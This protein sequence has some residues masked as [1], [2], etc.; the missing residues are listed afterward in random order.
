MKT[1]F[2]QS[3]WRQLS[4]LN[5]TNGK[6]S[7]SISWR[8]TSWDPMSTWL[9]GVTTRIHQ[10][11][12]TDITFTIAVLDRRARR[13]MT[14]GMSCTKS[15]SVSDLRSNARPK[16]VPDS[17]AEEAEEMP[18]W[19]IAGNLPDDRKLPP[20]NYR[21]GKSRQAQSTLGSQEEPNTVYTGKIS[22]CHVHWDIFP[23]SY[24]TS[25]MEGRS[26]SRR[27]Q[28]RCD[29][30]WWESAIQCHQPVNPRMTEQRR[31]VTAPYMS[32]GRSE[33]EWPSHCPRICSKYGVFI[34]IPEGIID[35]RLIIMLLVGMS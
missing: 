1:N 5:A 32:V 10:L 3:K 8:S 22:T 11:S 25:P 28:N 13:P 18:A 19:S 31:S 29:D 30:G 6:S 17:G 2:G 7:S 14:S 15:Y 9:S 33:K 27:Y 26:R 21:R 34:I 16:N 35:L 20:P 4:S 24:N 12:G 23:V